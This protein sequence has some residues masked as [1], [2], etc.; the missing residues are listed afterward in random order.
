MGTPLIP[1]AFQPQD[2]NPSERA[3]VVQHRAVHTLPFKQQGKAR[4]HQRALRGHP[5]SLDGLL[6]DAGF[7]IRREAPN[8]SADGVRAFDFLAAKTHAPENIFHLL[9]EHRHSF[10]L[11][12]RA[13]HLRPH[14]PRAGTMGPLDVAIYLVAGLLL[15]FAL[16]KMWRLVGSCV[17]LF[18]TLLL[19]IVAAS[20][21]SVTWGDQLASLW[22]SLDLYLGGGRLNALVEE[23]EVLATLRPWWTTYTTAL[24]ERVSPH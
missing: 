8:R 13:P 9:W 10:F 21:V 18:L 16:V 22:I 7:S 19:I 2:L 15:C 14:N 20:V 23:S 24:R 1:P 3:R 4:V 17:V 11:F 6:C 12:S 5:V